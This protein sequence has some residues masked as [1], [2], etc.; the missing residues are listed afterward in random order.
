MK[1][2]RSIDLIIVMLILAIALTCSGNAL[3]AP[4]YQAGDPLFSDSNTAMQ[5]GYYSG[6]SWSSTYATGD[7]LAIR[8]VGQNYITGPG[9]DI[10]ANGNYYQTISGTYTLQAAGTNLYN[11]TM[12]AGNG[13][14][15]VSDGTNNYLTA[16]ATALQIDLTQNTIAWGAVTGVNIT[17]TINSQA[18][19]DLQSASIYGF[20]TFTFEN[21]T[22]VETAIGNWQ[23][24]TQATNTYLRYYS[25]LDGFAPEPAE[26]MLIIGLGLIGF[27]I[28][29]KGFLR[30]VPSP[31]ALT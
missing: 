17:N 27:C 31:Q 11:L 29:R 28:Q 4:Y 5:L 23:N 3:A 15:T 13:S 2:V 25:E 10:L 20:T 26:W 1:K 6:T 8:F 24:D 9:G 7:S 18:L 19:T 12:V 22:A 30:L 21:S 14:I 16:I